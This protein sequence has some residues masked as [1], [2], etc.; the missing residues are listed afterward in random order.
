METSPEQLQLE[1]A[2]PQPASPAADE[3]RGAGRVRSD[4]SDTFNASRDGHNGAGPRR[5]GAAELLQTPGAVLTRSHLRELGWQRRAVDAIFRA[6]PVVAVDGYSRPV[7][8]VESYLGLVERST[9]RD[10]RVRPMMRLSP[11]P[12]LSSASD[13]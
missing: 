8:Q 4:G 11:G 10:D 5:Y 6:L 2:H 7:I 1:L 12:T 3:E 13:G 9:Y